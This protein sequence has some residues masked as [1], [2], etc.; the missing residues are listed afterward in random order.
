MREYLKPEGLSNSPSYSH[1]TT[2]RGEKLVYVSGQVSQDAAGKAVHAGD[3]TKQA[4][5]TFANLKLALAAAGATFENLLK[6]T[7]FVV[8]LDPTKWRAVSAVRAN[9]FPKLNPP[10]STMVGVTALVLPDFLIEIEAIASI[11]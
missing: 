8:D 1:T 4:E 2:T 7:I 5:Q 11:G 3:L 6:V 10:A 9:A